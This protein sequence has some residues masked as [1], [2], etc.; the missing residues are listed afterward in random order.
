[1]QRVAIGLILCV[2]AVL[3]VAAVIPAQRRS[4]RTAWHTDFEKAAAESKRL[5]RPLLVHF[6][7]EWCEPCKQMDREFLGK[8]GFVQQL[9]SRIVAVKVDS[10]EREDL[11]ERFDV[12][13]LPCDVFLAPSGR[14]LEKHS[15]YQK[16]KNYLARIARVTAQWSKSH[17][18][19]T[20]PRRGSPRGNALVSQRKNEPFIGLGGFSPVT[21]AEQRVW[22]KGQKEFAFKYQGI[23]FRMR[24]REEQ[25]K[26]RKNPARFAPRL[27]GCDPVTLWKTDRAVM[28]RIEFTAVYRGELYLFATDQNRREFRASPPRYIRA[29][30]VLR[31]DQIER[32][33]TRRASKDGPVDIDGPH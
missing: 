5:S 6:H 30:H 25:A 11:V 31:V 23:E 27:L 20:Q 24:N 22:R 32:S 15:G 1:M 29:R 33:K 26:F 17:R 13:S 10:D 2:V 16:K 18:P 9:G 21:L 8:S 4:P 19:D 7:A 3:G 28:G 12:D 14:I